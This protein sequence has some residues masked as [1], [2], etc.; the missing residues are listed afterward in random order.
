METNTTLAPA[1]GVIPSGAST[2]TR[3]GFC[4]WPPTGVAGFDPWISLMVSFGPAP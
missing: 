4:A 1:T 3:I 2:R